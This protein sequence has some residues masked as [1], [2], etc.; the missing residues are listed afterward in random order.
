[1][2][3]KIVL[4][5]MLILA[6]ALTA[7]VNIIAVKASWV[8]Q[9]DINKA[10][11]D[12]LVYLNGTQTT[13]GTNDG[14]W[15]PGYYAG[16]SSTAL[17]VLCFENNGHLPGGDPISDPYVDVVRRGLDYLLS[18]LMRQNIG[19]QTHGDP[20]TN[21]NGY[22]IYAAGGR[23]GYENGMVIMA[24]VASGDKSRVATPTW[25]GRTFIP[26]VDGHTYEE[27]VREIV[28]YAAWAQCDSGTG[29][30]GW[31][32]SVYNNA[33][34]DSDNSVGPWFYLG[35]HTA[36]L[37]GINA[38][39]FVKTELE[40]YWLDYSQNDVDGGFGYSS[41][42]PS[43]ISDTGGGIIGLDYCGV[44][45]SDERIVNATKWLADH[46][47]D[48]SDWN[49]NFGNLYAMYN[50][51]KG[52]RLAIPPIDTVGTHD[53]YN[54][55]ADALIGNQSADGSWLSWTYGWASQDV[56]T[57]FGILILQYVPVVVQYTLTV[58]V[59]DA[60]TGDP[61]P[62][63]LVKVVGPTS[64]SGTTDGGQ[65][66]FTDLQ[67]G[68]YIVSASKEGYDSDSTSIFLNADMEITLRL[69]RTAPPPPPPVGGFELPINTLR[70]LAPH[71]LVLLASSIALA[72][73]IS[74][75]AI[76]FVKRRKNKR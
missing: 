40:D 26:E 51:M 11:E 38:P 30:G 13:G 61:I 6:I 44:P 1:M 14:S 25:P 62:G 49:T 15:E 34:G 73:A 67:A 28:D 43:Y 65:V 69:T 35:L 31:R 39:A 63:A 54:E 47:Y 32:Y 42:S 36:E 33:S 5:V 8:P 57:A 56:D 21:G 59:V 60:T 70:L 46:W 17:A 64:T 3:L 50:I 68:D 71:Q 4:V 12:G 66:V 45:A 2:K 41:P 72:S 27:I 29:R 22:G 7:P 10:I 20:D 24:L 58:K 9:E 48:T 76:V 23:G 37:W 52:M 74:I 16:V 75:A 55:Y 18:K 53:W 19:P